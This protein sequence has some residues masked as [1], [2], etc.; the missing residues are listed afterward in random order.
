MESK[1]LKKRSETDRKYR[2]N[3]EAMISDESVID[4]ELETY[5]G[6]RRKLHE[7]ILGTHGRVRAHSSFRL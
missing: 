6:Q 3:I 2:W 5:Q 4:E 7:K 1:R